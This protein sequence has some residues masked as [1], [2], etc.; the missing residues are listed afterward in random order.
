MEEI[1]LK[2]FDKSKKNTIIW[3]DKLFSNIDIITIK[4]G[5]IF[6]LSVD[7]EILID[8]FLTNLE[9]LLSSKN[10]KFLLLKITLLNELIDSL[11]LFTLKICFNNIKQKNNIIKEGNE[12]SKDVSIYPIFELEYKRPNLNRKNEMNLNILKLFD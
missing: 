9:L 8:S 4:V 11:N 3:F 5:Y 6:E 7:N 2:S 10:K 1:I 12:F